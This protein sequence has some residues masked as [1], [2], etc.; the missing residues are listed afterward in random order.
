VIYFRSWSGIR[1]LPRSNSNV[2]TATAVG[3]SFLLNAVFTW[4]GQLGKCEICD[5]H[6]G[7]AEDLSL[8]ECKT[9][10]LNVWLQPLRRNAGRTQVVYPKVKQSARKQNNVTSQHARVLN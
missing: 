6:S 8:Q 3:S 7:D 9:L 5:S 10:L 4:D 1:D 2:T